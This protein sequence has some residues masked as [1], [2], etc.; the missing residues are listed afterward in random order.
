MLRESALPTIL[1]QDGKKRT[2]KG[3]SYTQIEGDSSAYGGRR[4][5]CYNASLQMTAWDLNAR[6]QAPLYCAINAPMSKDWRQAGEFGCPSW[7]REQLER[8]SA[9]QNRKHIEESVSRRR[10]E[11]AG[12][13]GLAERAIAMKL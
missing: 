13:S 12:S 4:A 2:A 1:E 3:I 11:E 10:L 8:E 5:K 6:L 7:T 9:E